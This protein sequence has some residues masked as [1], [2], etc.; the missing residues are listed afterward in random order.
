MNKL[1]S[2]FGVARK[3]SVHHDLNPGRNRQDHNRNSLV[4][5]LSPRVV[6]ALLHKFHYPVCNKTRQLK[7]RTVLS[8]HS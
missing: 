3:S 1:K 4:K 7:T 2:D 5:H 6:R 8:S